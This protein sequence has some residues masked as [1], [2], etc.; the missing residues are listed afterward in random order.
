MK[1]DS[2]NDTA[3]FYVLQVIYPDCCPKVSFSINKYLE[4]VLQYRLFSNLIRLSCNKTFDGGYVFP[5]FESSFYGYTDLSSCDPV[6][7]T[8]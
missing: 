8:F 6:K 5:L 4:L 3:V 2:L 7:H 1:E